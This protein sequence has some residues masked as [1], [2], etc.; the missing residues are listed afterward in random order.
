MRQDIVVLPYAV[1]GATL[2]IA[3]PFVNKDQ[4]LSPIAR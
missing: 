2:T 4:H 1:F 3:I